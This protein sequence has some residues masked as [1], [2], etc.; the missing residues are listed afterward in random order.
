MILTELPDLPPAPETRHNR[1]F[2][3]DFYSQWGK[4]NWIVSGW[5]RHAEYGRF[6]QTLSFK[7][8]SEG[9]E[10]YLVDGRRI[11][12]TD[13]TY[14]VLN[15]GREY[16]SVLEAPR[17]AFSFSIFVRPGLAT[18]VAHAAPQNLVTALDRGPESAS[19]TVEFSENL[20][21]HDQ[22]VTPVLRYIRHYVAK[23][24]RDE[25]W[26][27]EQYLFLL[28]QLLEQERA[29]PRPAERLNQAR[30]ATRLELERRIGWALDYMLANLHCPLT[31]GDLAS[32]ARLSTFH[33]AH[34][35][36]QAQGLTPM[37]YLRRAR[38][39]LALQLLES[40]ELPVAEVA[41]K[42][43]LSR[44]ALWRGVRQLRGVPPRQVGRGDGPQ[45]RV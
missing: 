41:E 32:A 35:F 14:L 22:R 18:E 28:A 42:V 43:G 45:M 29:R 36:Q 7:M 31:L 12:V 3:E 38:L 24:E 30:P 11:T 20:R 17:R 8:V 39:E 19:A 6:R 9:T 44:L 10:R 27:D 5:A 23:G 1:A 4:G 37:A 40:R 15:E 16:S 34:V 33:F 13:N 2:R 26:L 25:A 21:T